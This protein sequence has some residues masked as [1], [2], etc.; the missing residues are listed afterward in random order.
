M[1]KIARDYHHGNLRQAL[2]DAALAQIEATGE[3]NFTMRELAKTLGVSSAAPFRHFAT[4][5]ALLAAIAE[6]GYERLGALYDELD[7]RY[8]DD[9]GECFRRKGIAY[10]AFAVSNK[11]CYLAIFSP[12]LN[13]KSEFPELKVAGARVFASILATVEACQKQ[14]LLSDFC[15]EQ[16]TLTIWSIG[17]G[18]AELLLK[19]QLADL[20]IAASEKAAEQAAEAVTAVIRAGLWKSPDV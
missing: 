15:V 12:E 4:K 16:I 6:L 20:G 10:V 8:A 9:P 7:A 14:D 11:A 17:H 2:L 1:K 19:G 18:L 3:L 13:D 5:R